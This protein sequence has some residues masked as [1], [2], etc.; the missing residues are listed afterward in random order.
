MSVAI[1]RSE[2]SSAAPAP[3][4]QRSQGSIDVHFA[5]NGTYSRAFQSGCL[6]V[7]FPKAS[8]LDAPEAVLLNLAGGIAGG[9]ALDVHIELGEQARATVTSQAYERVYRS[10]GDDAVVQVSITAKEGAAL[11]YLPQ[12]TLLFDGCRLR[13]ETTIHLAT[14]ATLLAVEG[15][16]FGRSAM[17]ETVRSGFVS[18]TVFVRRGTK[19][20][21][22]DRFEIG[23]DIQSNLDRP[24]V[25][26]GNRAMAT[27]R[28]FGAGAVDEIEH[29]RNLL[30][31]TE[32][33]AAASAWDEILL[34]RFAAP[35]GRTLH[36]DL[37]HTILGWP[38]F[39]ALPRMWTF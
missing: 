32:G 12:P 21:H 35:D 31:G 10:S 3:K 24:A 5:A 27:L 1:L 39:A 13:R 38:N 28:Y 6:K 14:G 29:V 37:C 23:G 16:I 2:I 17:G 9:D 26:A 22:A 33:I 19:L 25:L 8:D 30:T 20:I 11:L 7:R 15:L 34:A 18:D 36:R 4:L